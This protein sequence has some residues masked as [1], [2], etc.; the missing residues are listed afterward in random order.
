MKLT[1]L[2]LLGAI[3]LGGTSCK[4]FIDPVE[5]SEYDRD[6]KAQDEKDKVSR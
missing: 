3:A 6:R 4:L 5:K 2:A 1:H